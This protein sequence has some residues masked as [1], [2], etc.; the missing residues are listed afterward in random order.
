MGLCKLSDRFCHFCSFS[1][2]LGS[3]SFE[4]KRQYIV[5]TGNLKSCKTTYFGF[6]DIVKWSFKSTI[7]GIALTVS[8][9]GAQFPSQRNYWWITNI[10]LLFQ[11]FPLYFWHDHFGNAVFPREHLQSLPYQIF[12]YFKHVHPI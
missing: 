11:H 12:R 4:W 5:S 10:G 3:L 7:L 2:H 1:A 9:F 6:S 8:I